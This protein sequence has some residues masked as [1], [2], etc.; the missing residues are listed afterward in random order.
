[1]LEQSCWLCVDG[2]VLGEGRENAGRAPRLCQPVLPG[3]DLQ[4]KARPPAGGL[5]PAGAVLVGKEGSRGCAGGAS[6]AA[7]TSGGSEG[8]PREQN[9]LPPPLPIAPGKLGEKDST[10]ISYLD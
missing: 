10:L 2:G 7:G 4:S 6:R 9:Q 5:G 3:M 8:L 1:M